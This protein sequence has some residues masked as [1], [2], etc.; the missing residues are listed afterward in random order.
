M[1]TLCGQAPKV[2]LTVTVAA[3]LIVTKFVF[4]GVQTVLPLISQLQ[5][6]KAV[7]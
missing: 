6:D 2:Q 7:V 3:A 4:P 1:L 5:L